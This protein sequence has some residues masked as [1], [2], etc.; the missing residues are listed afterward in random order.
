MIVVVVVVVVV[1]VRGTRRGE[2][3][4]ASHAAA[5][6]IRG[7]RAGATG[8]PTRRGIAGPDVGELLGRVARDDDGDVAGALAD[9]GGAAT[10]TG[11][12]PLEGGTLVGVAR[13]DVE[14]VGGDLVVV[15]GVGD[16]RVEH[17][18]DHVGG[19]AL[20][21]REDLVGLTD[22]LATDEVEDDPRLVGREP[23]VAVLG[24][25]AR[26]LVGLVDGCALA[27]SE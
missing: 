13:R 21:E 20:D 17:L 7:S 24:P 4:A 19:V 10:S 23:G 22:G 12:P 18:A 15:L 6:S 27:G 5:T 11:A 25:G 3:S 1:L 9:A 14:L 2:L 16:R 26:T 8:T